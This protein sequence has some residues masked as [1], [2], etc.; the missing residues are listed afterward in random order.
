MPSPLPPPTT[1]T[2]ACCFACGPPKTK[3]YNR[4]E[5][6]RKRAVRP[7]YGRRA[8]KPFFNC[9]RPLADRRR[10][11]GRVLRGSTVV[12]G[13]ARRTPVPVRVS[14]FRERSR[15]SRTDRAASCTARSIFRANSSDRCRPIDRESLPENR[16]FSST[17]FVCGAGRGGRLGT[18]AKS[19]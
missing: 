3:Y 19:S 6:E 17:V 13:R 15:H 12:A 7:Q 9:V 8:Q 14:A 2:A 4:R 16:R 11:R 18:T 1:D 10:P 5:T